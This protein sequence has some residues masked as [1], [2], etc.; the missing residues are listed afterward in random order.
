MNGC[1]MIKGSDVYKL[2][3]CSDWYGESIENQFNC[4]C[5]DT[6]NLDV[7]C[8]TPEECVKPYCLGKCSGQTSNVC[9][10][11]GF[12]SLKKCTNLSLGDPN[13]IFYN[14]VYAIPS[15]IIY[16]A[17]TLFPD[18]KKSS[19]VIPIIIGIVIV[20]L[21]LLIIYLMNRQKK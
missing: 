5:G 18:K 6:T 13:F 1:M 14:Y 21:V 11:P 19:P 8:D 16:D 12:E 3:D 4:S 7:K 2:E 9:S 15:D 10:V 17:V 20:I